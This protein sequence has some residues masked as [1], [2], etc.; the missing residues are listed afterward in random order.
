MPAEA[1]GPEATASSSGAQPQHF[2]PPWRPGYARVC[3]RR[4]L[5]QRGSLPLP[6]S[7]SKNLGWNPTQPRAGGPRAG[8]LEGRTPPGS[9]ACSVG[10]VGVGGSR[11]Q[12]GAQ[13]RRRV[14]MGKGTALSR[15]FPRGEKGECLRSVTQTQCPPH[16]PQVP[17]N[18]DPEDNNH[19]TQ[20]RWTRKGSN[21][22]GPG[23]E[24]GPGLPP[25]QAAS[26]SPSAPQACWGRGMLRPHE[27]LPRPARPRCSGRGSRASPQLTHLPEHGPEQGPGR[28]LEARAHPLTSKWRVYP[29]PGRTPG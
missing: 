24:A 6:G 8:R 10:T 17:A 4:C 11:R 27:A 9:P 3:S 14:G 16:R 18:V 25:P 2:W 20:S 26:S 28:L 13:G 5:P 1:P 22:G 29:V 12:R 15:S 21:S 23:G 7:A 19:L